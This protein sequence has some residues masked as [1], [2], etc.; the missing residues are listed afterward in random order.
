MWE[1]CWSSLLYLLWKEYCLDRILMFL[2]I[3]L[4]YI[5]TITISALMFFLVYLVPYY[6]FL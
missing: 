2:S 3:H 5:Y 6:A 4:K 1:L